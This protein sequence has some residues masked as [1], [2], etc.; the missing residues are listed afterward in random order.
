MNEDKH[1]ALRFTR[2]TSR[3]NA[4]IHIGDTH[5]PGFSFTCQAHYLTGKERP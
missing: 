5:V 2:K 4:Q 3:P 1:V